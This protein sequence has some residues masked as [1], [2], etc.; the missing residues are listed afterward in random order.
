MIA[1]VTADAEQAI[2]SQMSASERVLRNLRRSLTELETATAKEIQ[3]ASDEAW[4]E[5]VRTTISSLSELKITAEYTISGSTDEKNLVTT[6]TI[7]FDCRSDRSSSGRSSTDN[8]SISYSRNTKLPSSI[9]TKLDEA[10][11]LRKQIQSEEETHMDLRRQLANIPSMERQAQAAMAKA[12]LAGSEKGRAL[13]T[14][15]KAVTAPSLV[16]AR[17]LLT[18]PELR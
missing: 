16:E 5:K 1:I 14:N 7:N 3:A 11:T 18:M 12:S 13:L 17:P 8:A 15:L 9:Q 6:I 2:K 10:N 4:G